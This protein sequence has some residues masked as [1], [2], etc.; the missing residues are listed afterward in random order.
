VTWITCRSYQA[1]YIL[2]RRKTKSPRRGRDAETTSDA[3]VPRDTPRIKSGAGV[4]ARFGL[5]RTVSAILTRSVHRRFLLLIVV[6]AQQLDNGNLPHIIMRGTCLL[7]LGVV[8]AY[9][10]GL[11]AHNRERSTKLAACPT[12]EIAIK[13]N[14]PL[15]VLLAHA[16]A[17]A[18]LLW[19]MPHQLQGKPA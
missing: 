16:A 6:D 8:L 15:D 2:R 10:G 11:R 17:P 19:A 1:C 18:K 13:P 14:L 7:V 3:L 9:F 4:S 12:A 5:P